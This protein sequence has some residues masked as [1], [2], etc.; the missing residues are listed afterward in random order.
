VFCEVD[1]IVVHVEDGRVALVLE[2]GFDGGMAY[3]TTR[4]RN[5]DVD[6]VGAMYV[7]PYRAPSILAAEVMRVLIRSGW[8]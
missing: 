8:K 4:D 1:D 2:C 5:G 6:S 7:E 3:C